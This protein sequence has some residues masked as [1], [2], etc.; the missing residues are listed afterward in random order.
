ML[1]LKLQLC[2]V[3]NN[4]TSPT[5]L[6]N[7]LGV[8]SRSFVKAFLRHNLKK[9]TR[10]F[11]DARESIALAGLVDTNIRDLVHSPD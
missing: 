1:E 9:E 10:R 6:V 11:E 7:L 5:K 2:G 3:G 8:S 4:H